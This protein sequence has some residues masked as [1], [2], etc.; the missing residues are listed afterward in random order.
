MGAVCTNIT[1]A[2]IVVSFSEANQV[3][4]WSER[5]NPISTSHTQFLLKTGPRN[6]DRSPFTAP[7]EAIIIAA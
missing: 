5:I 3:E 2:A 4:K 6:S 1:L 7:I